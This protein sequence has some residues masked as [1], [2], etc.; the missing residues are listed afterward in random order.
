MRTFILKAAAATTTF[1]IAPVIALICGLI[2]F[3]QVYFYL[4]KGL[5]GEVD[6]IQNNPNKPKDIWDRHIERQNQ[7]KQDQ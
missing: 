1:F 7:K 3:F 6:D 2:V 5:F 4:W